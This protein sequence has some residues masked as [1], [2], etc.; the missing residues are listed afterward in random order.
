MATAAQTTANRT[1][2]QSSTGPVTDAG[3]ARTAQN[4][5]R[6]GLCA[7]LPLTSTELPE[8]AQ[9]LLD[10]LRDEHEPVGATEEI[11]VHKMV[12]HLWTGKRAARR[13][14]E[15]LDR[16]D[17]GEDTSKQV[18]LMLRY[19][20]AAERGYYKALSELRKLQE[21]R[22]LQEIGFVSQNAQRSSTKPTN[23]PQQQAGECTIPPIDY[24]K[25]I[26]DAQKV[27]K[28]YFGRTA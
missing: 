3:K 7:T 20:G 27:L 17:R 28:A 13:L 5:I 22:R 15:Q 6:H 25:T 24:E 2:S 8:E 12:E 14:A 10:T 26:A 9:A 21:H 4:A 23:Q 18:S 11:L 1:N 19:Q 16:A